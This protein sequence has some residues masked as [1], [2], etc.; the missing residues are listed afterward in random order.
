MFM[1]ISLLL[2]LL[3]HLL[4]HAVIL[5]ELKEAGWFST[6]DLCAGFHQIP[7]DPADTFKIAF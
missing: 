1:L 6:L 4:D 5:D 7:M 2:V 3:F